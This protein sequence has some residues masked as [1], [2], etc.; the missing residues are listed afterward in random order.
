MDITLLP[1]KLQ[2]A[3]TIPPSKSISHRALICAA[4]SS[5][6]KESIIDNIQISKD[7]SATIKAMTALGASFKVDGSR[8][9]VQ[10]ISIPPALADIDCNE[11]GSTLRFLIPICAALG[12]GATFYGTGR[13][14]Q[15]PLTP[16]LRELP[17]KNVHF[18]YNDTMPFAINGKLS[19]G[20]FELEGDI[21]SQFVTGLLLALPLLEGDS[22]IVMT[23]KLESEPYV[24]LTIECMNSFGVQVQKSDNYFFVKGG[25]HYKNFSG[26]IEGDYSQGAFFLVANALGSN[27]ECLG[28]RE[29]SVQGDKQIVE[30]IKQA[31]QGGMTGFT[32]DVGDIP[33]LAPI[34]TVLACGCNGK[35]EIYNGARLKTKESDRIEAVAASVNALGGNCT[36]LADKIIVEGSGRLIG[37]KVSSYNDHRIAMSMAIASTICEKPVI[38]TDAQCVEKSYPDFWADFEA[39]GNGGL[40]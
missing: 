6:D 10:G 21:S 27:I 15:R 18:A 35:S 33:D 25:Q 40:S 14:P 1:Q 19:S 22:E 16:Y 28:L 4:L 29:Y 37:G 2:G 8:V 26:E 36:P 31:K 38:I 17:K 32:A 20:K 9:V 5:T 30:I 12:V 11:S 23:S 7:I 34:L 13:L 3:V 24:D 39:L